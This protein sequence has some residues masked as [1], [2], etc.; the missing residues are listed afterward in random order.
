MKRVSIKPPLRSVASNDALDTANNLV[1]TFRIDKQSKLAVCEGIHGPIAV[2]CNDWSSAAHRLEKN[3]PKPLARTRHREDVCE[4]VVIGEL[5]VSYKT[6]QCEMPLD[7]QDLGQSIRSMLVL[8]IPH[9]NEV[10][11]AAFVD[12][13]R[14]TSHK[15]VVSLVSLRCVKPCNA[16]N[17]FLVRAYPVSFSQCIRPGP[18]AESGLI[19]RV[20]HDED[21]IRIYSPERED[22]VPCPPADREDAIC[23]SE[24]CFRSFGKAWMNVDS[25]RYETEWNSKKSLR[26]VRGRTEVDVGADYLIGPVTAR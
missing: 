25:V 19:H 15:P 10:N 12:E 17:D 1:D 22:S 5:F 23:R 14:Q 20:R 7:A 26:E 18:N 24:R 3:N 4:P 21:A 16:E 9:K 13:S 6:S 2:A 8:A 11:R